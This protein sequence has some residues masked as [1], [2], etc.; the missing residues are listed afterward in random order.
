MHTLVMQ[1]KIRYWGHLNGHV[2][3][4]RRSLQC[5]TKIKPY[6][7]IHGAVSRYNMF[8]REKMKKD[9]LPLFENEGLG[10]TIWSPLSSGLHREIY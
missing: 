10:T 1:G 2:E 5:S 7:S 8:E 4:D 9:Y 6:T 3:R